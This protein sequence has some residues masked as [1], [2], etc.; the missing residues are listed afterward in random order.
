MNGRQVC[1]P[2]SAEE[3]ASE[4]DL[5]VR[6]RR[7]EEAAF[8]ALYE[9]HTPRVYAICLRISG[10]E[11][12]AEDLTRRSFICAF[13]HLPDL[14]G[15]TEFAVAV[16]QIAVH[17]ALAARRSRTPARPSTGRENGN[18][19]GRTDS[20]LHDSD[21]PGG[22]A[23]RTRDTQFLKFQPYPCFWD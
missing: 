6:A 22:T 15:E 10:T 12:G 8:F 1:R 5:V 14:S 2:R 19:N 17:M 9:L 16:D 3:A 7:G 20:A 21:P 4:T 18:A 11:G 13:R 23:R